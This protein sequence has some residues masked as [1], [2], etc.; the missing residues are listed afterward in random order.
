MKL[1]TIPIWCLEG[2]SSLARGKWIEAGIFSTIVGM[3][4]SLPSQEGSGLK[5]FQKGSG[6]TG[7][8][9]SLAR[10]KWIEAVLGRTS[11]GTLERLPSQEGS[12]LKHEKM[13]GEQDKYRS[14]LAR[15]KWI[16]AKVC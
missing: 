6:T 7:C 15:G 2:L 10:G 14:S 9:S 12:G 5:P 13:A 1:I 11:A 4:C 8:L 16:E 3:L